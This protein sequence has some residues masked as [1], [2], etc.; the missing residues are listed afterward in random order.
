MKKKYIAY[1]ANKKNTL[2]NSYKKL[3]INKIPIIKMNQIH[4]NIIHTITTV[5]NKILTTIPN[6]DGLITNLKH[7][8]LAIKFAD[9]MPIIIQAHHYLCIL[10]AGRKGTQTKIVSKAIQHLKTLT[11]KDNHFHIWLGP[12]ICNTCYEI[13]PIKKTTF[14]MLKKT[15]SQLKSELDLSKNKLI[16]NTEC[17]HISPNYHSYRGNNKTKKRNY[18]ICYQH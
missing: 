2:K 1:T 3:R 9:C 13:D 5:P 11:Q 14:S 12:H 7:V 10:H 18:I 17:T 4:S 8:G 16:I 15:I 6:T